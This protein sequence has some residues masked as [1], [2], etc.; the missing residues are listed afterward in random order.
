MLQAKGEGTVVSCTY[1]D[2]ALRIAE[3]Q[4]RP[5]RA[6]LAAHQTSSELP[7]DP[8][9]WL[10]AGSTEGHITFKLTPQPDELP[11]GFQTRQLSHYASAIELLNAA[12]PGGCTAEGVPNLPPH[13]MLAAV[14]AE[15]QGGLPVAQPQLPAAVAAR[16]AS[17]GGEGEHASLLCCHS[18]LSIR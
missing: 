12:L 2:W 17:L 5:V 4:W 11:D 16:L 15:Q 9:L 18:V 14:Q 1:N 7:I 6:A 10:S 8:R 3:S 13:E